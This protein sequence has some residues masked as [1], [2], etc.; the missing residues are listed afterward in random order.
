MKSSSP[1]S[2]HCRSSKTRIT[3]LASAI[4][5]KNSRQPLN[6]SR[7][8][9]RAAL[10]EPEQVGQPRLD[11]PALALVGDELARSSRRSFSRWLAGS[12]SS[13]IPAR[14]RTI[15]ASAQ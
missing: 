12:S 15:S 10:L 7:G 5:S 8:L 6:R 13:L 3:G 11:Q 2:A 4:R 1:E 9:G 14:A